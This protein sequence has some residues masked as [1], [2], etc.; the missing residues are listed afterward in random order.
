MSGETN[1]NLLSYDTLKSFCWSHGFH[2][3]T[4][5]D[6]SSSYQRPGR[7]AAC[8]YLQP[9]GKR[10]TILKFCSRARGLRLGFGIHEKRVL[11]CPI[12]IST[13]LLDRR[14]DHDAYSRLLDVQA[15]LRMWR[16]TLV[17]EM[18]A[19]IPDDENTETVLDLLHGEMQECGLL[20]NAVTAAAK[21]E[22][23]ERRVNKG[24]RGEDMLPILVS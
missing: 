5:R 4:H 12:N 19:S 22:F 14:R 18:G 23:L 20:I 3:E 21:K 24:Y 1:E 6:F 8:W 9:K 11:P 2:A 15:A 16:R 7:E 17:T 10:T 13:A